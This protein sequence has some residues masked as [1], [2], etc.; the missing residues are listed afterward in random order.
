M[1]RNDYENILYERY[2]DGIAAGV[3]RG[4][5]QGIEQSV[6]KMLAAGMSCEEVAEILMIPIEKVK[7]LQDAPLP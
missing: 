4:I 1:N 2:E 3:K 6:R 5:E 7:S